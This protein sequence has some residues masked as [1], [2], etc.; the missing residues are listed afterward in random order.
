MTFW[1]FDIG[2]IYA[3]GKGA[4]LTIG[5]W[6]LLDRSAR[7]SA[8]A[9]LKREVAAEDGVNADGLVVIR[10]PN[11]DGARRAIELVATRLASEWRMTDPVR[12]DQG[13]ARFDTFIK[14]KKDADPAELV[15]ELEAR[16][17]DVIAV[18]EYIPYSGATR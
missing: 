11:P 14:L 4:Q 17:Q 2:S 6:R 18:A 5:D 15:A 10:T 12:D 1:R 9:M 13:L 3:R 8:K 16:W 7:A